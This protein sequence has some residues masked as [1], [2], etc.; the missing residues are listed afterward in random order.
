[1]QPTW[2]LSDR[3]CGCWFCDMN[4]DRANPGY[5]QHGLL[6]IP[7]SEGQVCSLRIIRGWWRGDRKCDLVS[8]G[9]KCLGECIRCRCIGTAAVTFIRATLTTG[10]RPPRPGKK[11]SGAVSAVNEELRLKMEYQGWVGGREP[12][13]GP[14]SVCY[15]MRCLLL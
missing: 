7:E 13:Y 3:N 8:R 10:K 1:M 6:V 5:L 14:L 4:I 15:K 9:K 2:Q 12:Q 11:N